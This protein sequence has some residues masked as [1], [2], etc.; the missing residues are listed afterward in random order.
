[1]AGVPLI[2]IPFVND[3]FDNA[4]RVEELGAGISLDH[5][6]IT[7]DTLKNAVNN[8]IANIEHYKKGVDK[9]VES[10]KES[11]N[12]RKNIYEKIFV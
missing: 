3:Q 4:K 7:V 10:F 6:K 9:I 5:N 11:I 12:N 8:I 2:V 1:M